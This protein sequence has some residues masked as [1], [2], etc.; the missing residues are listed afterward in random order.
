[1]N[2][3]ALMAA[4]TQEEDFR[5][6]VYDD[7]T[8][9]DLKPG[10]LLQGNPTLAV[11]WNIAGLPCT[12]E[13]GQIILSYWVDKIWSALVAQI[14]WVANLP[15]PVQRALA[16]MAFNM[17]GATQLLTFNTFLA[18]LQNGEY[19][20]AADDLATTLWF[21]QVASRGPRIQALIRQGMS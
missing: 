14:P 6:L 12:P 10:M 16:D 21:K 5:S 17:R 18:L 11:G 4:L 8:G 3:V 13:L 19:G 9:K 1:M 15:D 7:K 2:K 20:A